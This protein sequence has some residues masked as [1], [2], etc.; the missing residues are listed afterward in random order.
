VG[1]GGGVREA[2]VE[3]GATREDGD[4]GALRVGN[5]VETRSEARDEVVPC[6]RARIEDDRRQQRG[7]VRGDRRAIS[8]RFKI[9]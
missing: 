3:E 4:D 2:V 1:G 6:S 5:E 9:C 8:G 7:G